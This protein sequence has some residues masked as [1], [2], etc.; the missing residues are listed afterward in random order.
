[1]TTNR[2]FLHS[3][4][5]GEPSVMDG[6]G[7]K[8]LLTI[9]VSGEISSSDY[10]ALLEHYNRK[11]FTSCLAGNELAAFRQYHRNVAEMFVGDGPKPGFVKRLLGLTPVDEKVLREETRELLSLMQ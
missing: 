3:L 8:R 5:E 7:L 10:L 11:G 6:I 9:Y 2:E 1:M 4:V